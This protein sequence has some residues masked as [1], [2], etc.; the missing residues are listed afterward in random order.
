MLPVAYSTM[1]RMDS[2]L[3]WNRKNGAVSN[4]APTHL[5]IHS[6]WNIC[7]MSRRSDKIVHRINT[8]DAKSNHIWSIVDKTAFDTCEAIARQTHFQQ[9]VRQYLTYILAADPDRYAPLARYICEIPHT[10][11][12]K[13]VINQY[14]NIQNDVQRFFFNPWLYFTKMK[15][16]ERTF[17]V[18]LPARPYPEIVRWS[19]ERFPN[20]ETVFY[21]CSHQ[22]YQ[23]YQH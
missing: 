23:H 7:K 11:T 9:W 1:D 20:T 3:A 8:Y 17:F 12:K 21:R 6:N 4:S 18:A 13:P 22:H 14:S 15:K 19:L 2:M 5:H 10:H 16:F